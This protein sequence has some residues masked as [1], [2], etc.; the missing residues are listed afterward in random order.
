MD[1]LEM[2]KLV[3]S[4]TEGMR[5]ILARVTALEAA[6]EKKE[7]AIELTRRTFGEEAA[8]KHAEKLGLA[9][10]E[11]AAAG[12]EGEDESM[13]ERYERI[14]KSDWFKRTYAGK[15]LGDP[16]PIRSPAGDALADHVET[17]LS[18]KEPWFD[19]ATKLKGA[20]A[21]Y[22]AAPRGPSAEEVGDLVDAGEDLLQSPMSAGAQ[23]QMR[24]ALAPFREVKK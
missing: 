12:G 17:L 6:A 8:Q 13:R 18:L 5:N 14:V 24:D 9:H 19:I 21:G 11:K 2:A 4:I 3:T 23:G 22:R 20:L 7:P 1:D 15:S 10:A 16:A